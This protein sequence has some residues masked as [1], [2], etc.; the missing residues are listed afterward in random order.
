MTDCNKKRKHSE[1]LTGLAFAIVCALCKG[2]SF[3]SSSLQY[4]LVYD[5]DARSKPS[6]AF[7][8][9]TLYEPKVNLASLDSSSAI[10]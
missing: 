10:D 2:D 9:G 5:T 8:E 4:G 1:S 7:S 3:S 6:E